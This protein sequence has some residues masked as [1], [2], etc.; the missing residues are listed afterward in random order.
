MDANERK[1]D[2]RITRIK[3]NVFARAARFGVRRL[4]AA[5]GFNASTL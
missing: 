3:A 4:D 2:P 5:F 1:F